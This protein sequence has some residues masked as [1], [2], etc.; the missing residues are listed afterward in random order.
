VKTVLAA[1]VGFLPLEDF[2]HKN[3]RVLV[4][5]FS[6]FVLRDCSLIIRF[7]TLIS[8]RALLRA[9]VHVAAFCAFQKEIRR[10][11]TKLYRIDVL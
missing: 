6:S 8:S 7:S 1:A 3:L 4:L 2:P 5:N 11:L 10:V 9:A